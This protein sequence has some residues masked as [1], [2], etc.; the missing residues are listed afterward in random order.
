[1]T[2]SDKERELATLLDMAEYQVMRAPSSGGGTKRDLP[3]LHWGK[4]G[5][6]WA[7]EMKYTG[8][9]TAYYTE[10]EVTALERFAEAFGATA[11]L[12]ARFKQDTTFYYRAPAEARRTDKDNYAIDRDGDKE[13]LIE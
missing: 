3:D 4:G 13:V 8:T 7:A 11:F 9:D 12:V 1:M 6:S 10:A 2:G 5:E